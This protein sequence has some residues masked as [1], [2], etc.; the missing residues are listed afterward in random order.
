MDEIVSYLSDIGAPV[1]I[2]LVNGRRVKC[3]SNE[4]P[5]VIDVKKSIFPAEFNTIRSTVPK[6]HG[7]DIIPTKPRT[8]PRPTGRIIIA[9][10]RKNP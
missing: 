10:V 2:Y 7:I 9:A 8:N 6:R 5:I 4:N 1:N 3:F